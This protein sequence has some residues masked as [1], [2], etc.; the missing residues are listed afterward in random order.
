[1]TVIPRPKKMIEKTGYTDCTEFE[2][3]GD[4]EVLNIFPYKSTPNATAFNFI[5]D[6]N[7]ACEEY[8]I[9]TDG[10]VTVH[11]STLEGAYR[12]LATFE[13]IRAQ[14]TDGKIA[15]MAIH[16]RPKIKRRAFMLDISRGRLPKTSTLKKLIDLMAMLRQWGLEPA[17]PVD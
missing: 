3:F 6:T 15:N 14:S 1:M 16:D 4:G 10:A 7:L 9:D 13:Q 12:A 17:L 8:K 5:K 2:F 11:Y